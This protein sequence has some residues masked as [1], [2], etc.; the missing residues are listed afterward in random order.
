[1][2]KLNS[3]RYACPAEANWRL[4]IVVCLLRLVR[5]LQILG[6]RSNQRAVWK[7][8]RYCCRKAF[9]KP[10]GGLLEFKRPPRWPPEAAKRP[11]EA[12]RDRQKDAKSSPRGP[13]KG[14]KRAQKL[15]RR[16]IAQHMMKTSKSITGLMKELDFRVG[17]V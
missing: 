4:G 13:E 15:P 5:K 10:W 3:K 7:T 16:G 11:Q 12:P 17:R 6:F 8:A 2:L 14:A 9:G 1:M